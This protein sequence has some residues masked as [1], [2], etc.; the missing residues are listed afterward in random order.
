MSI[1]YFYFLVGL[2]ALVSGT[3][4][5]FVVDLADSA[6]NM[7]NKIAVQVCAGL[8]NRESSSLSVYTLLNQPY[9]GQ[10]LLDIEGIEN[11]TLTYVDD[12]LNECLSQTTVLLQIISSVFIIRHFLL[13]I[14]LYSVRLCYSTSSCPQFNYSSGC[15]RCHSSR[16][17]S[18]GDCRNPLLQS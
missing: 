15:S 2:V 7:Q 14:E 1:R 3:A 8:F 18:S 10:W 16:S 9:D 17:E 12:F 11:P 5:D 6:V 13:K 4:P